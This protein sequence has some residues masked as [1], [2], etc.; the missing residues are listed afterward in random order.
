[1]TEKQ[2]TYLTSR[3]AAK[4]LSVAVSTVQLWTNNGLLRAWTT[5]GGHRRIA[6]SSVEEILGQQQAVSG[7]QGPGQQ[8]S[9]V[10]VEDDAQQLRMYEKQFHAWRI[11]TS[12]VTAKDGYEGL[13][14]IG[15]TLPDVIIADLNLPNLDGFQ[16]I[17]ALKELPE[18]DQCLIVVVSGLTE[19]E[20]KER[21]GLPQDVFFFTKPIPFN[22]LETL[23]RQIAR[24]KAA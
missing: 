17:R 6:R 23:L 8:L 24:A 19:L 22:N 5:G 11:N 3:E 21:G 15:R 20:I 7:D 10:I 1:M 12:V 18:L 4:L 16:M 14:K 9:V 2:K 13:V